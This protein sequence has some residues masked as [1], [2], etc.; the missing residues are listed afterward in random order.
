[1]GAEATSGGIRVLVVDDDAL[2]AES[3]AEFL[4]AEGYRSATAGSLAEARAALAA[5]AAEADEGRDAPIGVAIVDVGMPG[6]SGLDLLREIVKSGRGTAVVMLTGYGTVESAV[7]AL[8]HGAVDFLTKPA[9][10]GELRV[11]LERAVRQHTLMAENWNLKRRLEDRHALSSI[12]GTDLRMVKIFDLVRA[13]A[14]SRTTVLMCGESGTGKSLIA[15][16]IHD[17]S[18]R[19]SGAFVELSCGSIPETLLESELFGHVKGAFTGAHVDKPGRFLTANGG[20][21]F[22]DEINSASP[23]MQLKLLRVLQ[24]R[25]F[26]PVGSSQTI[27]VDARVILASNQPLERLVAEG[28]FRQDLYYRINVVKIELPPLRER[29]GD[30]MLLAHRFLARYSNELGKQVVGFTKEA[31]A[32]IAAYTFPGNVR[33]LQNLVERGVVLC[34]GQVIT[35]DELPAPLLEATPSRA[36]NAPPH[37]QPEPWVPMTLEEAMRDPERRVLLRALNANAWNRQKTAEQLGVNR[38]T[39]YKKL[40][41]L[42]I[43][44]G[45]TERAA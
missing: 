12:A 42:G 2:V 40:K 30:V 23:A 7:E 10:E 22:L 35:E 3:L 26:E 14:P 18:P 15:H 16:A 36:V 17:L 11:S 27:E 4:T 45:D 1:M 32:R 29:P 38:T 31:E 41:A 9:A 37:A 21:I 28:S 44:S 20:T 8:R 5:A 34:R 13:V 6:G 39:L 24:E 25:K 43:E 33:E 19:R